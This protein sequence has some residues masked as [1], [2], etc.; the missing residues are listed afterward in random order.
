[1]VADPQGDLVFAEA[2]GH[3]P[4]SIARVFYV[5]DVPADAVRGGH[6]HRS[7]WHD[8]GGFSPTTVYLALTSAEFE[9]DD[10]IRDYDEYLRARE[11]ARSGARTSA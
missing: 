11:A 10:Y 7:L 2:E 6:A 1:M 8:L 4:F 9:E 5:Y 3:V